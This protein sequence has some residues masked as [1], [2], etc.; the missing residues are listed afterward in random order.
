MIERYIDITTGFSNNGY[1]MDGSSE[2]GSK[3]D[4]QTA[5]MMV[6]SGAVS[7][8]LS[9][10][11]QNRRGFLGRVVKGALAAIGL[12]GSALLYGEKVVKPSV[13][14]QQQ[15]NKNMEEAHLKQVESQR[16]IVQPPSNK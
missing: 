10:G 7:S 12:G 11:N 9:E 6:N 1:R 3:I 16:N 14:K 8:P 13:E 15:V 5:E 4:Q 2:S